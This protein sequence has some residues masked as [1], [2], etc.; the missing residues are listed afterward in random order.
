MIPFF[1]A[2]ADGVDV[3]EVLASRMLNENGSSPNRFSR[4]AS[5]CIAVVGSDGII[6][7]SRL[8]IVCSTVV[9]FWSSCMI[10]NH[11]G[12]IL[13]FINFANRVHKSLH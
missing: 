12:G 8:S 13:L 1:G 10:S 5:T 11:H 9:A 2:I 3:Y 4:R 7:S 6:Y